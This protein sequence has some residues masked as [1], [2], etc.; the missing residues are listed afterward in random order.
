MGLAVGGFLCIF[1]RK[2]ISCVLT[3][4]GGRRYSPVGLSM[5]PSWYMALTGP[6]V[7]FSV[8]VVK[9]PTWLCRTTYKFECNCN[10]TSDGSKTSIGW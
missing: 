5:C 6:P 10:F 7:M 9:Q 2:Y 4:G 3:I 8:M 1:L